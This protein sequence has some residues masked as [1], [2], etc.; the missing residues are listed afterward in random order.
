MA[1]VLFTSKS[2]LTAG[3]FEIDSRLKENSS[4]SRPFDL[5]IGPSVTVAIDPRVTTAPLIDSVD[6]PSSQNDGAPS[7]FP[8]QVA[9]AEF[10]TAGAPAS[11]SLE[12]DTLLTRV[13][14]ASK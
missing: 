5:S 13:R 12:F 10:W 11:R 1:C 9:T 8:C 6:P 3:W 2:L 14:V 7:L 4:S